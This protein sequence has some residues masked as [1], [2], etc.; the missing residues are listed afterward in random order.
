MHISSCLS[1]LQIYQSFICLLME[2]LIMINLDLINETKS[3]K[4]LLVLSSLNIQVERGLEYLVKKKEATRAWKR[5]RHAWFLWRCLP[6]IWPAATK[7]PLVLSTETLISDGV[8]LNYGG[9]GLEVG[10][11][12]LFLAVLPS[13]TEMT[14]IIASLCG[15]V[16]MEMSFSP[17]LLKCLFLASRICQNA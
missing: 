4:M 17:F 6:S 13:C 1:R 3:L 5:R 15:S 9:Q 12:S 10:F 8:V 11:H 2:Q 16:P 7:S 14:P